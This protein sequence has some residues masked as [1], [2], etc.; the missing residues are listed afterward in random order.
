[1]LNALD[2]HAATN[3]SSMSPEYVK[4]LF[5]AYAVDYE[6]HGKKLLYAAPRVLRQELAKIYKERNERLGK[7]TPD[8]MEMIPVKKD[9]PSPEKVNPGEH[10]EGSCASYVS[11]M[12]SELDVL[13]IGCGTGLAGAWVKDYAKTLT[14]VDLSEA[15]VQIARKKM[16]YQNLHV[17][18]VHMFLAESQRDYD[19]IVAADLLSYIGELKEL[20]ALVW[21][22]L[23]PEGLFAFTVENLDAVEALPLDQKVKG[24]RLMKT[25]RFSYTK[26]YI[27]EVVAGLGGVEVLLSRDFSPR[28]DAGEPVPGYIYIVQKKATATTAS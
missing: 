12:N 2:D 4:K 9:P 21:K 11:F 25:G 1:M 16:L 20:F 15:M 5:N 24:F 7:I 19:L 8:Q 17:A 22:N 28:L 6:D 10:V 27:D 23:R 26:R 13:D 3:V 14:G 18:P